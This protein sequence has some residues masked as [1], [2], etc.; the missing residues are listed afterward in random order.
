MIFLPFVSQ[1]FFRENLQKHDQVLTY[2]RQNLT[3]Q[4]NILR[5]LTDTNAE[6]AGIRK[7]TGQ[8]LQR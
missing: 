4:D 8:V 6:Y 5:A 7:A 2:I 3:A 1:T